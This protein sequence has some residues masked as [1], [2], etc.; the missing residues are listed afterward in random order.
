[1]QHYLQYQGMESA[2]VSINRRVDKTTIGH[3]HN[4]ILLGCKKEEN[5]TLF[6]SKD[7]PGEYHPSEISQSEK[8]KYQ[9]ISLIC[10][11][12]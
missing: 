12:K 10:G 3:L 8:D 2:Q 9:T 5:L 4:G 1:M 11:I 7:G 6:N